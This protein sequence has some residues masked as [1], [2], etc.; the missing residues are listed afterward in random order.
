MVNN[1]AIVSRKHQRNKEEKDKEMIKVIVVS[2]GTMLMIV[3]IT[4]YHCKYFIK[5]LSHN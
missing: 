2:I 1:E 4:W 5:E 3:V